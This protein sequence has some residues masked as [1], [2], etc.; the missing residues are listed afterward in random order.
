MTTTN[1]TFSE[2]VEAAIADQREG[3]ARRL[4][5]IAMTDI[6][7][8]GEPQDEWAV[9]VADDWTTPK[10]YVVD[11]FTTSGAD[12]FGAMSPSGFGP[13][14]PAPFAGVDKSTS[15][16]G[17]EA[18]LSLDPVDVDEL[19]R[20]AGLLTSMGHGGRIGSAS[21]YSDWLTAARITTPDD[22]DAFGEDGLLAW[23]RLDEFDVVETPIDPWWD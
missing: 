7:A 22:D 9:S 6:A 11:P 1:P 23:E 13:T 19:R 4:V 3:E 2:A 21:T 10:T 8:Y 15:Y 14:E 20:E 5:E 17:D 18:I 16:N 12:W